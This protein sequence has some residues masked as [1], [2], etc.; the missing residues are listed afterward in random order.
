MSPGGWYEHQNL[1]RSSSTQV[2]PNKVVQSRGGLPFYT[3]LKDT[4][5]YILS[6]HRF[7]NKISVG[8]LI[9]VRQ[10]KV[11][12]LQLPTTGCNVRSNPINPMQDWKSQF[13]TILWSIPRFYFTYPVY[14]LPGHQCSAPSFHPKKLL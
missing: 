2:R 1:H 14:E 9:H 13:I 8:V 6:K 10:L 4:R 5:D 7:H 12:L 3:V 11:P